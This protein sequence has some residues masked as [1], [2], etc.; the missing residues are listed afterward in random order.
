M[1]KDGSIRLEEFKAGLEKCKLGFV[2]EE[3]QKLMDGVDADGSGVIDYNE[4]IAASLA[5]SD[6]MREEQV[7]KAFRVFDTNGDGKISKQEL[8]RVIADGNVESMVSD[9][10]Q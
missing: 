7:W 4:F 5:Q 2:P 9:L 1:G 10:A 3:L 6:Y 8:E